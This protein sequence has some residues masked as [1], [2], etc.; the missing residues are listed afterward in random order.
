M[1]RILIKGGRVVDPSSHLDRVADVLVDHDRIQAVG[2]VGD[3]P[4]DRVIDARGFIVVP[5]LVDM[6]VHLREPGKEEE[7]TIASGSR[8]AV[9]GGVTSVA[10]MPNTDPAVDNEASAE[11]VVLQGKRAALANIFPIGAITEHRAGKKL[12]EMGGLVRAGA[13]AFSDD[14]L[15]VTSAETMRRGLLYAKLFGKP[16]IAHCEDLTL[17]GKGVMNQG[18][19]ST[20][21]GLPG[22][23][24]AAEDIMVARDIT[25]ARITG[26]RLHIGHMSTA[27]A[28]DL[29]RRGKQEGIQVTGEVTPHHLS[30]TDEA[31]RTF[32]TNFKMTPPLRSA[33]D[34]EAIIAGLQDGTIDVIATDHAPH[35]SEEKGLEF[36]Y[37]PD[38]VIGMETLFPICYTILVLRHGFPLMD[39]L[40]KVTINP[41]R[42]L[43]IDRG[44]LRVGATADLSIFDI[45]T[46]YTVDPSTFKSRSRNCPFNGWNVFGLPR[47][48]LVGGRVVLERT[49]G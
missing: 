2:D 14:M 29:L 33:R 1:S 4:V 48:V 40:R 49:E 16:I 31:V 13:V 27:G 22:I 15:P 44:T 5:G 17:R 10:C 41:A 35:S 18:L 39:V 36:S 38:G 37:A 24:N 26:G 45:T 30:L 23:P 3:R 32:D 11:F 20:T 28:V 6:H 34:V 7:E 43:G 42:I 47:Y 19:V 8:A 21:L 46:E 9:S 12:A 25:L